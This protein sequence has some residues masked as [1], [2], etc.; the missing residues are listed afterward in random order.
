ME[1]LRQRIPPG[2]DLELRVARADGIARFGVRQILPLS[3]GRVS[4]SR[5]RARRSA[6]GAARLRAQAG[7]RHRKGNSAI[8]RQQLRRTR[9]GNVIAL[10][11]R[12]LPQQRS[13]RIIL[14]HV[15]IGREADRLGEVP[16]WSVRD[17]CLWWV[18]VLAATLHQY[19]PI[20]GRLKSQKIPV[21][22]LGCVALRAR[23]G[24]V[25]GTNEGILA[26]D[27]LAGTSLLVQPEPDRPVH[28]LN[29]GRC[30]RNGRLWVGSMNER[31][32]AAGR[33]IVPRRCGFVRASHACS[34]HR[35]EFDRLQ[36]G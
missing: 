12:S 34:G 1:A 6:Q 26:F 31:A 14:D 3:D 24:L 32:F 15:I 4:L 36:P 33:H 19:V 7:R 17:N 35:S 22:S 20:T 8:A 25:L 29:D 23:G 5:R 21:R 11:A 2:A 27:P 13:R 9:L 30:D 16:V 10:G 18:D 28:R